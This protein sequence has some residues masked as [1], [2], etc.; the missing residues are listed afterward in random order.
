MKKAII[1]YSILIVASTVLTGDVI[2]LFTQNGI[3][4]NW[5]GLIIPSFL[6]GINVGRNNIHEYNPRFIKILAV[7]TGI[8]KLVLSI[9]KIQ[10]IL[11]LTIIIMPII[12]F[13]VSYLFLKLGIM[14]S[15]KIK[16]KI[17]KKVYK[18]IIITIIL[19]AVVVYSVRGMN[20]E[21]PPEEQQFIN[22]ILLHVN[23]DSSKD[24]V[25][26]ILGEPSKSIGDK[27]DWNVMING[28]R[29]TI[30]VYFAHKTGYATRINFD[31]G[32]GRFYFNKDL[33]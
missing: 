31:G 5:G 26:D 13:L 6:I 21:I 17:H 19:S 15:R 30:S 12:Y 2:Y 27:V 1:W 9:M 4:S 22:T 32:V 29:T 28:K 8:F 11:L 33:K 7:V 16:I 3:A 18:W 14:A 10:N 23:E 24:E 20:T 25:M